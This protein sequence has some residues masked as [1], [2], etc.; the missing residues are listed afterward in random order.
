MN[1]ALPLYALGQKV[2]V[3]RTPYG[4]SANWTGRI[5]EI[6]KMVGEIGSEWVYYFNTDVPHSSAIG[7][8][9]ECFEL[10]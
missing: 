2:R 1:D 9:A 3:V 10:A 8:R 5:V 6:V 7:F 4:C